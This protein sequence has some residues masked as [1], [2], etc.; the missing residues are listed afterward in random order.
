MDIECLHL[1]PICEQKSTFTLCAHYRF[2]CLCIVNL[3]FPEIYITFQKSNLELEPLKHNEMSYISVY[4][5][6][7]FA[8]VCMCIYIYIYRERE[9]DLCVCIYTYTYTHTYTHI[10][11][12]MCYLCYVFTNCMSSVLKLWKPAALPPSSAET[13]W[14]PQKR[15]CVYIYI[16]IE[17]EREMCVYIYIYIYTHTHTYIYIYIYMYNVWASVSNFEQHTA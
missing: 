14:V 16:Y 1:A 8:C 4:V 9:R 10:H 6:W 13:C 2:V 3:V 5:C 7:L 17:R 15:M 12:H 11:T